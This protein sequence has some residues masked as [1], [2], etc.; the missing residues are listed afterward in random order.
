MAEPVAGMF[1]KLPSKGDFWRRR[2]PQSFVDPWDSWLQSGL[3]AA[4]ANLSEDWLER[5]LESPVWHFWLPAEVCDKSSWLGVMLPSV[6]RVGRYFPFT[7]AFELPARTNPFLILALGTRWREDIETLALSVLD[8]DS[9]D[10][11]VFD[12]G[13][14][15]MMQTLQECDLSG[16]NEGFDIA[17]ANW[18]LP[19]AKSG[20]FYSAFPH[21]L[22]QLLRVTR[23]RAS[24]WWYDQ[25]AERAPSL[26]IAD[27]LPAADA[28]V[29]LLDGEWARW[30]WSPMPMPNTGSNPLS[31]PAQQTGEF[32]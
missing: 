18:Q 19:L 24:F 13:V 26:L 9:F 29:G 25:W 28:F 31:E 15:R 16:P 12:E 8:P 4:R 23:P 7:I 1:G 3:T 14:Q 22:D 10:E 30:G 11:A 32:V 2:L 20:A 17:A 21:L 27:G 5:Y 6:D